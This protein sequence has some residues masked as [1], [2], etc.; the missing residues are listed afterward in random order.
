MSDMTPEELRDL[1]RKAR[2]ATLE[3][4][5]AHGGRAARH[6]VRSHA[7]A[8]GDFT[9]RERD[10]PAPPKAAHKFDSRLEHE[11]AWT[12]TNLKR[13]GLVSN[14][15]RSV[16]ELAGEARLR[17]SPI[18]APALPSRLDELRAMPYREYLRTPEWRETRGAA[19]VRSGHACSLDAAHTDRLEVHHRS[20]DRLGE[21]RADDVIVLCHDC[22]RIHHA[23]TGRPRRP[24]QRPPSSPPPSFQAG[25]RTAGGST[26]AP[27]RSW[28]AR[29]LG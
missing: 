20:Y 29:L 28:L 27:Q 5:R 15:A 6:D 4:L 21:E 17:P 1:R 3:A 18:A 8:H 13:E 25:V 26:R 10:A 12:L 16:W 24:S 9:H 2:I 22:H 23:H 11:L 19:L 14:P 7:L